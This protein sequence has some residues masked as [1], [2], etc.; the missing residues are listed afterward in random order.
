MVVLGVWQGVG[1]SHLTGQLMCFGAAV[2]YG[3][4]IPYQKRFIAGEASSGLALS[5]GQL[6]AGTVQIALVAPLLGGA[7]PNPASIPVAPSRACWPWACS[8]PVSRSSST[9]ATSGCRREH[10]LDGH[11]PGSVVRDGRRPPRAA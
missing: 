2:C 9:C 8:A 3:V 6:L 10:R 5:A 1:G 11:L 4:A 7:P